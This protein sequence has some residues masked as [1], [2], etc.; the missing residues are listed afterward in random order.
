MNAPHPMP[1]YIAVAPI[2]SAVGAPATDLPSLHRALTGTATPEDLH[3]ILMGQLG[4]RAP[5]RDEHVPSGVV[6]EVCTLP[7]H[8]DEA[9]LPY[10]RGATVHYSA[11]AYSIGG[12][13]YVPIT[14]VVAWE[15]A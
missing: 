13:E 10:D 11:A 1:G 12:Y 4:R 6:V 3:I 9:I 15:D 5:G 7:E 8:L 2:P 14:H